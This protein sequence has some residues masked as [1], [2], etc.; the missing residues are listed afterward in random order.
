MGCWLVG[1][2]EVLK[3][4]VRTLRGGNNILEK[5]PQKA[6][7]LLQHVQTERSVDLWPQKEELIKHHAK[8]LDSQ[9]TQ[10]LLNF[11][12]DKAGLEEIKQYLQNHTGGNCQF[13]NLTPLNHL[14]IH[15]L[16]TTWKALNERD[17]I[18]T[19]LRGNPLEK[20]SIFRSRL[21]PWLWWPRVVRAQ[22]TRLQNLKQTLPS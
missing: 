18:D 1:L 14:Q 20:H 6:S 7:S 21:W 17:Q 16:A 10:W 12:K 3:T 4:G 8:S 5:R 13:Q 9:E 11:S 15:T 2:W 22:G 19:G